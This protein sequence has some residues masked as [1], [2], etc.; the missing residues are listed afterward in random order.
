MSDRSQLCNFFPTLHGMVHGKTG[1][2]LGNCLSER[3]RYPRKSYIR[4]KLIET[5]VK[6]QWSQDL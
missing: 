3:L 2:C 5:R 6:D 4:A 1:C